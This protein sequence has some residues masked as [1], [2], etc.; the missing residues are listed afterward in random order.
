MQ[1]CFIIVPYQYNFNESGIMIDNTVGVP[2]H[3]KDVVDGL[4]AVDK[5]FFKEQPCSEIIF[6]RKIRM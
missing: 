5:S 1:F 3:G 6:E 4:N 2:G